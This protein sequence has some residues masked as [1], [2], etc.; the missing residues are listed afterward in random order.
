MK[1]VTAIVRETHL[2]KVRESL[3]ESDITRITVSK[4][5]GHGRQQRTEIYR[6][7]K[8]IPNLIPKIRIE[9]AV[10]EE[11]VEKTIE[12]II[13]GARTSSNVEEGVGD[14]KIFVTPLDQCIRIRTSER[15]S[16][17]I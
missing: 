10:N 7:K 16:S 12:A 2:D 6:G 17:A 3:I 11:F 13:R 15:G 5:S 9:I 4:V 14:G 1:L 8:V